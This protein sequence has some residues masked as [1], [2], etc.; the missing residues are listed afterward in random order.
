VGKKWVSYIDFE[1]SRSDST[2]SDAKR[3]CMQKILLL[4]P[5]ASFLQF[6]N[7]RKHSKSRYTKA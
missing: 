6:V 5:G 4:L 7:P 3:T 1:V 2:G